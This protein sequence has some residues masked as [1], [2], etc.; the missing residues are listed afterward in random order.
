MRHTAILALDGVLGS[1]LAVSLDVL[2]AAE[3]LA[4]AGGRPRPFSVRLL[5]ASRAPVPV[6]AGYPHGTDGAFGPRTRADVVIVP[7][8]VAPRPWEIDALLERPD[9]RHAVR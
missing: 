3:Q 7:G 9:A 5:G 8:V 1:S 2:A 6:G 4:A